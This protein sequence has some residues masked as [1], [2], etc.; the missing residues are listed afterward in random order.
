[1]A[2]PLFIE[3]AISRI[4]SYIYNDGL[5]QNL[6]VEDQPLILHTP[7]NDCPVFVEVAK[8]RRT[9]SKGLTFRRSLAA[10]HGMLFVFG[11]AAVVKLWTKN[12]FLSL[13]IIFIRDD[14][15][16]AR[17]VERA[18]PLSIGRISSNYEV[19]YALEVNAGFVA[20]NGIKEGQKITI[21]SSIVN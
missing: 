1:M 15:T 16:V 5:P 12:C 14:H 13:D 2:Y 4:L 21:P 17:V 9:R 11:N 8:T 19:L 6:L 7:E 3:M 20:A 10:D 18:P